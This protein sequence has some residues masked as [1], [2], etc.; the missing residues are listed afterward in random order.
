LK[1]D[2]VTIGILAIEA[3][4]PIDSFRQRLRDLAIS[5][6]LLGSAWRATR[7]RTVRATL[8]GRLP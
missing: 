1:G 2:V 5:R 4:P 8:C 3:F 6:S 7:A